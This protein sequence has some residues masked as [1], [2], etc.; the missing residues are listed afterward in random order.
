VTKSALET[1][2][3]AALVLMQR[4]QP[5]AASRIM[6]RYQR[7]LL[8]EADQL[9]SATRRRI[10]LTRALLG[11]NAG[12]NTRTEPRALRGSGRVVDARKGGKRELHAL[13]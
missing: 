7:M 11:R 8:A 10:E 12:A 9:L 4:P 3:R 6:D 1:A 5:D 2:T 13:R